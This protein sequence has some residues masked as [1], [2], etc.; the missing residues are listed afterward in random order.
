MS[1]RIPRDKSLLQSVSVT[2]LGELVRVVFM[3]RQSYTDR[4]RYRDAWV[5]LQLDTAA[6]CSGP[7][8]AD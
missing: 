7:G 4:R 2:E 6:V 5:S 1:N 3:N 8:S